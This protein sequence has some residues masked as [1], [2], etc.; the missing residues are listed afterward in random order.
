MRRLSCSLFDARR[1]VSW[2]GQTWAGSLNGLPSGQVNVQSVDCDT[3]GLCSLHVPAS[4]IAVVYLT[5]AALD[6]STVQSAATT[7]YAGGAPTAVG[8][9]ASAVATSNGRGGVNSPVGS[10]DTHSAA[11]SLRASSFGCLIAASFAMVI[12]L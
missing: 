5:P 1:N 3:N 10:S 11:L 2:A 8:L 12:T 4:S 7:S 9:A 6:D